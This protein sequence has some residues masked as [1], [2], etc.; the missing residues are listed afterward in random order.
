M[1]NSLIKM[2]TKVLT[3]TITATSDSNGFINTGLE[4][5]KYALLG[6]YNL[7]CDGELMYSYFPAIL[8]NGGTPAQWLSLQ[9]KRWDGSVIG[10]NKQIQVTIKYIK[11]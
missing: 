6:T 8:E 1:A 7:Y 2:P 10:N 9:F 3:K 5:A 11:L 4:S